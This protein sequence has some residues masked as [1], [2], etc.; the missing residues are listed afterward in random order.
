MSR[1]EQTPPPESQPGIE[2]KG[3]LGRREVREDAGGAGAAVRRASEPDHDLVRAVAGR[4]C[5]CFRRRQR[6]GVSRAGDGREDV[7]CQDRRVDAG[8]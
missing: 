4:G 7:A 3:G 6:G 2:G 5:R 8:E 1:N